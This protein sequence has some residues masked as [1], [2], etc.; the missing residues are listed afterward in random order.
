[1]ALHFFMHFI[2][3]LAALLGCIPWLVSM[4]CGCLGL[5]GPFNSVCI[6]VIRLVWLGWLKLSSMLPVVGFFTSIGWFPHVLHVIGWVW[7][8]LL[9]AVQA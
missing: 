9:V 8:P 4:V 6:Y 5:V 1:M 3:M 7:A 2:P